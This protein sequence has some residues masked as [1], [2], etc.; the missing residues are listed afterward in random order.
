[1]TRLRFGIADLFV[2]LATAFLVASGPLSAACHDMLISI[3]TLDC[4]PN[5]EEE[6]KSVES[7]EVH[8]TATIQRTCEAKRPVRQQFD[9]Q[10]KKILQAAFKAVMAASASILSIQFSPL[11]C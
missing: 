6:G 8:N 3:T 1:M 5:D 9:C 4:D 11:R 2:T 7:R 10:F